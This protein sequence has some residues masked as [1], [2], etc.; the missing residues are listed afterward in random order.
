MKIAIKLF[1]IL[2]MIT[3]QSCT[4]KKETPI[5]YKTETLVIEQIT[6][7]VFKHKTYLQTQDFGRVGCNGMVY[8]RNNEA[9]IFDTPTSDAVSKEL[10]EWVITKKKATISGVVVNHFHKDCLGGLNEF[11]TQGISS[12]ANSLTI[13]LAK[14]KNWTLPQ[15]GFDGKLT[16][17][18][19]AHKVITQFLGEGHTKD[20]TVSYLESERVLYGGCMLKSLNASKGN[21]ED[22]NEL[23]WPN[24][25]A[26]VKKAFP[27]IE[28][29]IPGHGKVGDASLLDYT[30]QLFKK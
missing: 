5:V 9:L 18:L 6:P 13:T 7:T 29:V 20:N 27:N 11:H 19:G 17:T 15:N 10:I 8:I 4:T 30:I 21:L 24:T 12:Y 16:L 3:A 1:V 2:L 22:A 23:A 26:T 14:M 25:V 28:I